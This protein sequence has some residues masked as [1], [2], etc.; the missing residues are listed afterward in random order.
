MLSLKQQSLVWITGFIL[1]LILLFTLR[2]VFAPFIA[3]TLLA[4]LL[5]PAKE[6]LTTKIS[7]SIAA[8]LL[9]LAWLATLFAIGALLLPV[10]I[11]EV[12]AALNQ[13]ELYIQSGQLQQHTL[14]GFDWGAVTSSALQ[15][16]FSEAG[17]LIGQANQWLI[18]PL[19][20]GGN[21]VGK[22]FAFLL[23]A[24]L[25]SFFL[26]RDWDRFAKFFRNWL[27]EP[28]HAPVSNFISDSRKVL[29]DWL[30]GVAIVIV[31][32]A[33]VYV[34]GLLLIGVNYA[35]SV[36]LFAGII[37]FIPFVGALFATLLAVGLAALEFGLGWQTWAA[38]ALFIIG[39]LL[40]SNFLTPKLVGESIGLHPLVAIIFLLAGGALLG[41]LGVLLALPVAAVLRLASERLGD[42]WHR[43]KLYTGGLRNKREEP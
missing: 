39:Q 12:G 36:G 24:P 6:K 21:A 29:L 25:A 4:W 22:V 13:I 35:V 18:Q 26:L 27:P 19:I 9:T 42:V 30:R 34:A 3:G 5:Q 31:V 41:L 8:G 17:S 40:E 28:W 20:A 15:V 23:L 1:F 33:A 7:P 11:G 32:L 10:F 16:G 2:S 38:L 14:L 37:S 43:S